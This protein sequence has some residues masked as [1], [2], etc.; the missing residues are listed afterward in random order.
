MVDMSG[1][2]A[3]QYSTYTFSLQSHAV[4]TLAERGFSRTSLKKTWRERHQMF[5]HNLHV[6]F[7]IMVPSQMCKISC[8]VPMLKALRPCGSKD[9]KNLLRTSHIMKTLER[10]IL[11][12]LWPLVQPHLDPYAVCLPAQT[13]S[14]GCHHLPPQ[15][16]IHSHGQACK[17]CK[18]C[19]LVFWLLQRVQHLRMEDADRL[20][21][22]IHKARGIKWVK[23]D[24]KWC[25][26]KR[27]H[28]GVDNKSHSLHYVL[29]GCRSNFSQRRITPRCSTGDHSCL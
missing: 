7:S 17:H 12:Q 4:V 9:Y 28:P 24:L 5:L 10:T 29:A 23:L 1:L 22:L 8:I 26:R 19:F 6:A 18:N 11:E 13:W 2:H 3:G 25:Q 16:H 14:W 20:N 15:Q 27:S 21:R